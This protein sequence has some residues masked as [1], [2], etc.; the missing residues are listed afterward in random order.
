L[1]KHEKIRVG[2]ALVLLLA[3]WRSNGNYVATE[4][5]DLGVTTTHV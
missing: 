3:P 1:R 4:I 5:D 2:D